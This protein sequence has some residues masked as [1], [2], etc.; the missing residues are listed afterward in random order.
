MPSKLKDLAYEERLD[1]LERFWD[2]E[3]PRVGEDAAKGWKNTDLTI[4]EEL[5]ALEKVEALS[6]S[7]EFD[8]YT[9]WLN[10]ERSAE[11]VLPTKSNDP[12]DGSDPYGTVLF[13][14][15]RGY[16]V[17][18]THTDALKALRLVWLAL[19]G[20]P[21]FGLDERLS[22]LAGHSS[23][24]ANVWTRVDLASP[25]FIDNLFPNNGSMAK[26]EWE[27]HNGVIVGAQLADRSGFG[28]VKNWPFGHLEP[29]D[30]IK[31]GPAKD[32][33][34]WDSLEVRSCDATVVRN[35]FKH[36]RQQWD[37]DGDWDQ[38]SLAFEAALNI[39]R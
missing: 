38:L 18:I 1:A 9:R 19:L 37:D 24:R 30:A 20:L 15:I 8:P 34:Y 3:M 22:R 26:P 21:T 6:I 11:R 35:V 2:S 36:L 7:L 27:S 29:L 4:P 16:L 31:V 5:P 33:K 32:I 13:S 17:D 23:T 28:V 10:D 14:D 25:V 39:K 12:E